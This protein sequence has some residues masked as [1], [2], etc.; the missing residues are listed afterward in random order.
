MNAV[1][2]LET[3]AAVTFFTAGIAVALFAVTAIPF[4]FDGLTAPDPEAVLLGS[5]LVAVALPPAQHSIVS[6]IDGRRSTAV[7]LPAPIT[8]GGPEIDAVSTLLSRIADTVREATSADR[9]VVR[10]PVGDGSSG[11][12]EE[13]IHSAPVRFRGEVVAEIDIGGDA[14][15][16]DTLRT[17]E[18]LLVALGATIANAV[19]LEQ[20]RAGIAE[21]K[22]TIEHI[23]RRRRAIVALEVIERSRIAAGVVSGA[24]P[25]FD[26]LH[27]AIDTDDLAAAAHGCDQLI[28]FLRGFSN[29]MRA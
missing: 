4:G 3:R 24:E 25:I 26:G 7:D 5:L 15:D 2:H 19:A 23:E 12:T 8:E 6:V 21:L 11:T 13:P 27:A 20:L 28:E 14:V 29:E 9:A 1:R 16:G 17:Y 10:T 22:T 18:H